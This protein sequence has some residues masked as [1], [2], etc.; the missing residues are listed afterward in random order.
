LCGS[1]LWN[2]MW[3]E[4]LCCT[5]DYGFYV[6]RRSFFFFSFTGLGYTIAHISFF[7]H[8]LSWAFGGTEDNHLILLRLRLSLRLAG[9]LRGIRK[10]LIGR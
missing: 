7:L 9:G 4:K 1:M 6:S 3:W 5:D 8:F 10:H 2:G